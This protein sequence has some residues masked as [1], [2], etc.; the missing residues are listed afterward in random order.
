VV[1]VDTNI[2]VRF[3]ARDDPEQSP[4]TR[5]LIEAQS[6]FVTKTV[7]LE[8]EWV[9]R[10]TYNYSPREVEAALRGI[11]GLPGITLEDPS[12]VRRALDWLA[13][14]LDFADALHLASTPDGESFA[15]F[16]RDLIRRARSLEGAPKLVAP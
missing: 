13:A 11:V 7:L 2:L 1:S 10:R 4:R 15:T 12:A 16:D 5:S 9:L 14:G 6:A 3:I 8:T